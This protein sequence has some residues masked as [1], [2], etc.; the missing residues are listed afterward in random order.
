MGFAI[1]EAARDRGAQVTAVAGITT[2]EP[3][4]GVNL[5]RATSA[6]EMHAAV[7]EK[8]GK[9]SVFIAAAAVADYRPVQRAADKIKKSEPYFI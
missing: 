4:A 1:A 5:I 8:I 7:T 9:A 3:P 2:A 6:A